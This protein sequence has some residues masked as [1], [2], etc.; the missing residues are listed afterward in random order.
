MKSA[1]ILYCTMYISER[2]IIQT[3]EKDIQHIPVIMYSNVY[4]DK[5]FANLFMEKRVSKS[6]DDLFKKKLI[7]Q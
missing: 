7:K 4:D 3:Y 6:Y 2:D 5:K 1:L